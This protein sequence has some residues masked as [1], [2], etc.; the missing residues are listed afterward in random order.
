MNIYK[1]QLFLTVVIFDTQTTNQQQQNYT[2][3]ITL[4]PFHIPFFT[5]SNDPMVDAIHF[6]SLPLV[7]LSS[8]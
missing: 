3:S 2:P 1:E 7:T 4:M 6:L 8:H 5:P